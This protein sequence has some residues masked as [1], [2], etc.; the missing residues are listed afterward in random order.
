MP[1][2]AAAFRRSTYDLVIATRNRADALRLSLPLMID[3]SIPPEQVIVVDSSDDP[4]PARDAVAEAT[5]NWPGNVVL[6]HTEPGLTRQRNIGL[7]D[8]TAPIVFFF[9]DDSLAHPGTSEEILHVYER[10]TEGRIAGVAAAETRVPPDNVLPDEAWRMEARHQR[11]ARFSFIRNQLEKRLS[12]LKPSIFLGSILN[13]R[14]EQPGWLSDLDAVPVEYMTG[15]RMTFRTDAIRASGFDEALLGYGLDED[16]DASFTA[17]ASGLVVAARRALIFHH[18]CPGGRGG[19][20]TLGRMQIA[21]RAHVLLKHANG[22]IGSRRLSNRV[23]RRHLGFMGLKVLSL[24]PGQ[25]NGAKRRQMA[26]VLS[27]IGASFD[28]RSAQA[29][30]QTGAAA[31]RDISAT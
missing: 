9:D 20:Y 16:I 6:R 18:R 15:F 10:D 7:R 13:S 30:H 17:M 4:T 31:V 11:E 14:H 8:V 24:L 19:E 28:L 26:G 1:D 21:H 29:R 3:Q 23:W 5:R 27:G 2:S 22:P 25:L 12:A